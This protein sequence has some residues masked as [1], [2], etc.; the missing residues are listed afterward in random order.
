ME[1][2]IPVNYRLGY[3]QF[4]QERP[5]A[6]EENED[7]LFQGLMVRL[8]LWPHSGLMAVGIPN[9]TSEIVFVDDARP[10]VNVS[11][12]PASA[13][14][15]PPSA[16]TA[17]EHPAATERPQND[18]SVTEPY[19]PHQ[20][21]APVVSKSYVPTPRDQPV[22]TKTSHAQPRAAADMVT[23]VRSSPIASFEPISADRPSTAEIPFHADV[24]DRDRP[25]MTNRS[26]PQRNASRSPRRRRTPSRHAS[27]RGR[28]MLERLQQST[29]FQDKQEL[30]PL[31]VYHD[32]LFRLIN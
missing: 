5:R 25:P 1:W 9:D 10:L 3:S 20:I 28:W 26:S 15:N 16:E 17:V 29:A 13:A 11:A 21:S 7:G 24:Q 8:A 12:E 6:Y 22:T 31:T 19:I 32:I 18:E 27:P 30:A 2:T 23:V 14:R 4:L